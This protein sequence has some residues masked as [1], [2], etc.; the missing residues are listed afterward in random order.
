[1]SAG[2]PGLVPLGRD[3]SFEE[4]WEAIAY[5]LGAAYVTGAQ[6]EVAGGYRL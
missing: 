3:G 4:V 6:I 5:L 2:A 1:M